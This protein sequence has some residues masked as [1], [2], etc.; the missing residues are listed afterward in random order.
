MKLIGEAASADSIATERFFLRTEKSQSRKLSVR[1]FLEADGTGL[2]CKKMSS[3]IKYE[4]AIHR[5][6]CM[7]TQKALRFLYLFY[8]KISRTLRYK[9]T[10]LWL[11][12]LNQIKMQEQ[13]KTSCTISNNIGNLLVFIIYK[14]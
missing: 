7:T 12:I 8:H 2:P 13:N 4:V 14:V 11:Y 1:K 5:T 9:R 6:M 10:F 3:R